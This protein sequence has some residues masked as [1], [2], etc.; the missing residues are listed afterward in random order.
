MKMYRLKF[1]SEKERDYA[2][3]NLIDYRFA[4]KKVADWGLEV[5]GDLR[6]PP[7]GA[8]SVEETEIDLEEVYGAKKTLAPYGRA[9]RS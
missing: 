5:M 7:V 3:D 1:G 4:L 2:A 9:S 6:L 8:L